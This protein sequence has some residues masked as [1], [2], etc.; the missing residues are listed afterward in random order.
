MADEVIYNTPLPTEIG[1]PQ[2]TEWM[3]ARQDSLW[4]E[5]TRVEYTFMAPTII[6]FMGDLHVGHPSTHYSRISE[7]AEAIKEKPHSFLILLGDLIDGMHWNP[8]QLEEAE[9]IPEQVLYVQSLLRYL[10]EDKKLLL[11]IQGDHD[12][13]LKKMGWNL[14]ADMARYGGHS[15]NGPTAI[16]ANLGENQ[17]RI[18]AAHRLPGHSIYNPSH[19]QMRA[20]REIFRGAD[21]VVSGHTHRKGYS[22]S[23]ITEWD[24]VYPVDMINVGAYKPTD[25]WLQKNGFRPQRTEQMYGSAIKIEPGEKHVIVF[26][27][28]LKA[29]K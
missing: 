20:E 19:P 12:G 28:I 7:E 26:D 25:S 6:N 24:R 18:G 13:W 2:W 5:L 16:E 9:Q 10:A 23:Y 8:G 15:T 17:Y 3:I 11:A 4:R 14:Y 21:V 1:F 29:N 22:R 27:D